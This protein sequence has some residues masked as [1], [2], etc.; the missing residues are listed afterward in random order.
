MKS[1]Q[2]YIIAVVPVLLGVFAAVASKVLLYGELNGF[3]RIL[4]EICGYALIA[5]GVGAVGTSK[6]NSET[7]TAAGQD[8]E[9]Q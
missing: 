7:Q 5:I 2:N 6:G 3:W 8:Y 9:N 1:R 4:I